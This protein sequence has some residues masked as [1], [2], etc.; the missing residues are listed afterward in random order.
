MT[1][2]GSAWSPEVRDVWAEVLDAVCAEEDRRK[3]ETDDLQATWH[4]PAA[5]PQDQP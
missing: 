4:L 5:T 1:K 2:P 3:D